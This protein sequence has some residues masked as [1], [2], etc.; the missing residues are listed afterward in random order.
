MAD[1]IK[2]MQAD[3]SVESGPHFTT[4]VSNTGGS[5]EL[6]ASNDVFVHASERNGVGMS[7]GKGNKINMQTM[8]QNVVYGGLIAQQKGMRGMVPSTIGTP[9]PQY[10]F[11]PP[12]ESMMSTLREIVIISSS[13]L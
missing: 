7:P 12:L 1:K 13:F 6:G 11:S 4:R 5:A 3:P 9:T 2:T 8:P 10:A